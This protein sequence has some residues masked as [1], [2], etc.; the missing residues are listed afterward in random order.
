MPPGWGKV[1]V[2]CY[3]K[4]GVQTIWTWGAHQCPECKAVCVPHGRQH[5]A[6]RRCPCCGYARAGQKKED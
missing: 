6:P 3:D 5:R 4:S 1:R 2:Y